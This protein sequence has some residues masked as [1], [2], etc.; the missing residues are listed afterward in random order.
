MERPDVLV[1]IINDLVYTSPL[2]PYKACTVNDDLEDYID[3]II[4]NTH[5]HPPEPSDVLNSY[6]SAFTLQSGVIHVSDGFGNP[7]I[8]LNGVVENASQDEVPLDSTVD[9][10]GANFTHLG[11]DTDIG[12]DYSPSYEVL[13]YW[14]YLSF[15]PLLLPSSHSSFS[16][17]DGNSKNMFKNCKNTQTLLS[18]IVENIDPGIL[19]TTDKKTALHPLLVSKYRCRHYRNHYVFAL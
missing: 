17:S 6:Y 14:R 2:H 12:P 4:E 16:D 1:P 8:I 7:P 10:L 11:A 19:A 18:L 3:E 13:P 9:N 5:Q 15:P